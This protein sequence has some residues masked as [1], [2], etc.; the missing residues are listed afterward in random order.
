VK[1]GKSVPEESQGGKQTYVVVGA[2]SVL[3]T[4]TVSAA[5]VVASAAEVMVSVAAEV[6]LSWRAASIV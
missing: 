5:E 6:V 1:K 2:S 3:V 4:V